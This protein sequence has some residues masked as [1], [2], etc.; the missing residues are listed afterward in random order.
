MREEVDILFGLFKAGE[1]K[2]IGLD[3][4]HEAMIHE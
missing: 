2:L 3:M 4:V 1:A